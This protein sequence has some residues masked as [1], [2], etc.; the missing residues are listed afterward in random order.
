MLLFTDAISCSRQGLQERR[1]LSFRRV[2]SHLY[3]PVPG[4]PLRHSQA[5]P[6]ASFSLAQGVPKMAYPFHREGPFSFSL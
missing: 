4:P 5:P 6:F 2:L 3:L 1:F